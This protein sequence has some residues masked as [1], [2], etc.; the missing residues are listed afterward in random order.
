MEA[1]VNLAAA[2]K[3][4]L[5]LQF[6]TELDTEFYNKKTTLEDLTFL[7]VVAHS[8]E[9]KKTVLSE[10]CWFSKVTYGVT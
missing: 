10:M 2:Q 5:R 3:E 6:L 1:A 4:T 8:R 9:S 7:G